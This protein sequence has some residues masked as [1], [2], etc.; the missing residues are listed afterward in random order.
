M[1]KRALKN[2]VLLFFLAG[3][4]LSSCKKEDEVTP[5]SNNNNSTTTN[6]ITGIEGWRSGNKTF[7]VEFTKESGVIKE[8]D[9]PL[10]SDLTNTFTFDGVKVTGVTQDMTG[11]STKNYVMNY[12]GDKLTSITGGSDDYTFEFDQNDAT[13]IVQISKG[14]Q[15]FYELS[16]TG[17]NVS[18]IKKTQGTLVTNYTL[19]YDNNSNPFYNDNNIKAYTIGYLY[20][21]SPHNWAI[22]YLLTLTEN[23]VTQIAWDGK[24]WD[25]Q[26]YYTG[27]KLDS[28]V[29]TW[30]TSPTNPRTYKLTY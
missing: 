6:G 22:D 26:F 21:Q 29:Q 12:D 16:Y 24:T 25:N 17:N 1:K 11:G 15:T 23:N 9:L 10:R 28:V 2:T 18:S 14:T 30:S 19:T 13:R 20:N 27:S 7:D 8:F 5:T 3:T 4:V